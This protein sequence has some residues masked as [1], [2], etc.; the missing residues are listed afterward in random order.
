MTQ[1]RTVV[2][3]SALAFGLASTSAFAQTNE[4][5][6]TSNSETNSQQTQQSA[7]TVVTV[8]TNGA[9]FSISGGGFGSGPGGGGS[10]PGG[11]GGTPGGVPGGGDQD[12]FRFERDG[13]RTSQTGAA[14]GGV[15]GKLAIWV[16]GAYS[17]YDQD[18]VQIQADGDTWAGGVGADWL[19][20]DRFI[21]GLA[22]SGFFSDSTL[23]FNNGTLETEGVVASPY[24]VAI[25]G[26]DRNWLLDG[27][28]GYSVAENDSTRANGTVTANYDSEFWFASSNLT[29][30]FV[31]GN[32]SFA[33]K[34]GLLWLDASTD[35][36]TETGA[37]GVAV[38]AGDT[39]LG[40]LSFGGRVTYIANP[41]FAPYVSVIGEYDFE[42]EEY[43][44]F[45]AGNR[46]SVEDTGATVGLGAAFQL[47][48]RTSGTLEGTTALGRSDYSSYTL[49]GN[50]RFSF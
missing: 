30:Q 38:P 19:F 36:Y 2:L 27:A 11:G 46:P 43:N 37:G 3:A 50:L 32:F 42:T 25:L 31:R 33:P 5:T 16:N 6:E 17:T 26:R 4:N 12:S 40:R 39:Q 28:V 44:S 48:D 24:F 45:A 49:S 8:V 47:T 14:A 35:G 18:Q 20:S 7:T 1:L 15:D 29:Y 21:G 34:V 13:I 10:G 23:T 41:R 22:V 9:G